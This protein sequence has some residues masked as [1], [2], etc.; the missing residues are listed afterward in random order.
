[1]EYEVLQG[2][3]GQSNDS[4]VLAL[5]QELRAE[6]NG[7]ALAIQQI[8]EEFQAR[9][10][11]FEQLQEELQAEVKCLRDENASLR[12]RLGT[13][14]ANCVL[15]DSNVAN[16]WHFDGPIHKLLHVEGDLIAF[17]Q[18]QSFRVFERISPLADLQMLSLYSRQVSL[19]TMEGH[20]SAP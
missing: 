14:D 18:R 9:C 13:L 15:N 2:D 3:G 5:V 11:A 4:S 10:S 20:L 16:L 17:T 19:R 6:V 8:Q 12:S 1:M 7:S